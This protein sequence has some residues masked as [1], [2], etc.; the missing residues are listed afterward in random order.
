MSFWV[1]AEPAGLRQ[2]GG[3]DA[4]LQVLVPVRLCRQRPDVHQD[5]D[6][7]DESGSE[8]PVGV[9][10]HLDGVREAH[11]PQQGGLVLVSVGEAPRDVLRDEGLCG[12][13]ELEADGDLFVSF[14]LWALGLVVRQDDHHPGDAGVP[15]GVLAQRRHLLEDDHSDDAVHLQGH[16]FVRVGAPVENELHPDR[17]GGHDDGAQVPSGLVAQRLDMLED[18]HAD[19]AVHLQGDL[20]VRVGAPVGKGLHHHRSR[21]PD[22]RHHDYD[23]GAGHDYD[24]HDYDDHDYDYYHDDGAGHDYDDHDYAGHDYDYH[25]YDD[26]G[27]GHDH[28]YHDHDYH[29]HYDGAGHDHDD[30]ADH[31]HDDHY[32][33]ADHDHDGA[34]GVEV[35]GPVGDTGCSA[36]DPFGVVV[37]I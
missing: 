24:D 25:D 15:V 18:D 2:D 7:H 3:G 36:V 26:D 35:L 33:G 9:L 34:G 14:G 21:H 13:A 17:V 29:D 28:D 23:H 1:L 5:D 19:D 6:G 20:F 37:V 32:D 8:V 4:D 22:H 30:G 12:A 27:A 16:L 10:V 11:H 31:D